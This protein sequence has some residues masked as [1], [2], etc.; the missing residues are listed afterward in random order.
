MND[1]EQIIL[2]S[3][4]DDT[5]NKYEKKGKT[6]ESQKGL[7]EYKL[8]KISSEQM[9]E[10]VYADVEY[11]RMLQNKYTGKII[12]YWD[13]LFSKDPKEQDAYF[14]HLLYQKTDLEDT[15]VT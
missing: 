8:Y 5:S 3:F 14:M 10:D 11:H 9:K 6:F 4:L 7:Y 12:G 1:Q 13:A 2:E 15:M